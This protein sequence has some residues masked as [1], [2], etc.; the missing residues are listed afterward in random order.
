M[1]PGIVPQLVSAAADYDFQRRA[2]ATP[3][4]PRT[5]LPALHGG[6]MVV[7]SRPLAAR[8]L[9]TA[10][11]ADRLFAPRNGDHRETTHGARLGLHGGSPPWLCPILT[12]GSA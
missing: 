12:R 9:V 8:L 3:P 2:P 7:R 4:R 11:S 5:L 6:R 10:V 1:A